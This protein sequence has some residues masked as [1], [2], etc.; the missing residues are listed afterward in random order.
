MIRPLAVST[1][2]GMGASGVFVGPATKWQPAAVPGRG[3]VPA[4][5]SFVDRQGIPRVYAYPGSRRLD[6]GLTRLG[7]GDPVSGFDITLN[8]AKPNIVSYYQAAFGQ[9]PIFDIRIP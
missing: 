5:V 6:A 3:R 4:F 1:W 9:V 2:I 7:T 8:R